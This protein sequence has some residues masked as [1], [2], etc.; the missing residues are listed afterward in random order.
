MYHHNTKRIYDLLKQQQWITGYSHSGKMNLNSYFTHTQQSV[1]M[2]CNLKVKIIKILEDNIE[3][4]FYDL[5]IEK[6][7]KHL[8]KHMYIKD[9]I[10]KL[11]FLKI[12]NIFLLQGII[13]SMKSK[14]QSRKDIFSPYFWQ[15]TQSMIYKELINWFK[16]K[17]IWLKTEK[18]K[19]LK[20]EPH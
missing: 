5:G 7:Y 20:W 3:E 16:R 17:T 18:K 2:D 14:P 4:Y 9:K 6:F 11:D 15:M 10:K 8:T 13:K 1:L 19:R 12:R